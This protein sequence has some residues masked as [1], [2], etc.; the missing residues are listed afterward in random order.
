VR[1]ADGAVF[2]LFRKG[3]A[4]V[5]SETFALRWLARSP[6]PISAGADAQNGRVF[7]AG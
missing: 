1:G 3:I 5:N 4:W 2:A 7:F 6:V